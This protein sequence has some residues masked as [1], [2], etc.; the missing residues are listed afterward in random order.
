MFIFVCVKSMNVYH[1]YKEH[2]IK[3]KKKIEHHISKYLSNE[4]T[5][6]H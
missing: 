1:A 5:S 4:K 2:T 3:K 6:P